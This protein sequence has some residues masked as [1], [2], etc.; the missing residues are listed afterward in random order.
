MQ[1]LDF[2]KSVLTACRYQY[3]EEGLISVISPT[4]KSSPATIDGKRLV[5]PTKKRLKDGFGEEFQAF[6]PLAESM[7]RQGTSPVLQH[8]QRTMKANIAHAF[9][10]L[11]QQMMAVAAD[12]SLHNDLPPDVTDYLMKLSTADKTFVTALDQVFRAAT[13]KN[14][15]LTVYLK[16]GGTFD[17]KKVNRMAVIRFPIMQLLDS[18]DADVMGVEMRKKHRQAISVLLRL[19]M[20]FGDSPEEYSAGTNSRVAP[21]FHVLLAA[22]HK[23][24]TQL[25]RIIKRYGK[26]LEISL[27]PF[28][29]YS[30][31]SLGQ[32]AEMYDQVPVL[33]GNE[34][35]SKDEE[36]D[37][38]VE[39]AVKVKRSGDI[40]VYEAISSKPTSSG[41]TVK[42]QPAATHTAPASRP[43][44]NRPAP[45][46]DSISV[47]ELLGMVTPKPAQYQQQVPAPTYG[48]QQGNMHG[49]TNQ[50]AIN[51][52]NA[53][54][55]HGAPQAAY[56]QP[57]AP[58][59]PFA[60]AV[61]SAR[62]ATN[63]PPQNTGYGQSV[64]GG[65][66]AYQ[67]ASL[68]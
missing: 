9:V 60:M 21:Y 19:I 10:Y 16:N 62:A 34:G 67:T 63:P 17:G 25:N 15:L 55:G 26:A 4:G 51:Q 5:L 39:E 37:E 36:A 59:N 11:A 50:H 68:L 54:T 12:K 40:D 64:M 2:Y 42:N 57:A 13:R 7:A 35:T 38:V 1:I 53:M 47:S 28:E 24:I 45:S 31:K 30:E 41:V 49:G 66:N 6:H 44:P 33:A 52:L 43:Q 14:K 22:Y 20:P 8:I 58:A 23:V 18:D 3:D 32:F 56:G 48:Y 29:L 65:Y 46:A 27:P 61:A